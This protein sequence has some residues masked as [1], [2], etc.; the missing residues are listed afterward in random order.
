MG[1]K[2]VKTKKKE[3]EV[4]NYITQITRRLML[5]YYNINPVYHKVRL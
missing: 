4:A 1:K 3:V 2:V 5:R